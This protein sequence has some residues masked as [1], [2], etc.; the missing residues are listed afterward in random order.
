MVYYDRQEKPHLNEIGAQYFSDLNTF[1][2]RCD[3]VAINVR[4]ASSH[5]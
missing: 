3:I 1:L 2:G 4:V 5:T